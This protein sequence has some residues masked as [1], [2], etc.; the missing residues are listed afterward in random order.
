MAQKF[1]LDPRKD[2]E[3]QIRKTEYNIVK[4]FNYIYYHYKQGQIFRKPDIINRQ[5][6]ISQGKKN[7]N[8]QDTV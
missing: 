3:K 2:P 5:D 1:E 8:E 7:D 6:L 4:G